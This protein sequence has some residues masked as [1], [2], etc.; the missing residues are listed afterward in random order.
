[1]IVSYILLQ[2]TANL[3]ILTAVGIFLIITLLL[4]IVLL[5]ANDKR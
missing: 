3:T 2:N 4:V 5:I 1:M